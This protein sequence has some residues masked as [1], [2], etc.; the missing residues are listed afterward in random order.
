MRLSNFFG[1]RAF[2]KKVLL[3]TIP[4]IIQNSITT[5]VALLDNI[6]VGQLET[7]QMSGVSVANQLIMIFNLCIFGATS[8]AGIFT[9]QF[10]GSQNHQGIRHTVRYKM[11]LCVVLSIGVISLFLPFGDALIRQYLRGEGDPIEAEKTLRAGT[12]YLN[13]MVIGFIPFALS[14]VY[15]STLRECGESRVPMFSGIVAVAVNLSLNGVLIFGLLGFPKLGVTGAAIA[16]VISRYV[17]LSVLIIWTHRHH[18]QFPFAKGLYRSFYIP[19]SL[20]RKIFIKG[21]PLLANEFLWS[22]G[23]ATLIQC[24]STCGLSVVPALNISETINNLASV[25]AFAIAATV[26]ILMGQMIG[27]RNTKEAIL[28]ANKKLLHLAALLGILFGLLLAVIA[29]FFP[30]LY[31]ASSDVR[32]LSTLLILILATMKPWMAYLMSIY[33]SIRSGGKTIITFLYDCGIMWGISIPLAFFLTQFTG[34]GILPIF[35]ICQ[36][37]DVVKAILGYFIIRKGTWIQN[38]SA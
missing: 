35:A 16:T 34:L 36:S 1:D 33:Y 5:F 15:A 26:G 3:F 22:T 17:E 31:N 21:M 12:T 11:I 8:G 9:A 32:E 6:M 20:F 14:N 23:M 2:L 13:W 18:Q 19:G 37:I 25:V 4:I 38:L 24:Y 28:D 30:R 10:H 7:S 29:P 27:S